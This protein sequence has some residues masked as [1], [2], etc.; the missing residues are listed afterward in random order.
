LCRSG[1]LKQYQGPADFKFPDKFDLSSFDLLL[2]E[3]IRR[4]QNTTVL[5]Y[6]RSAERCRANEPLVQKELGIHCPEVVGEVVQVCT[7]EE[8]KWIANPK[9]WGAWLLSAAAL[10]GALSVLRDN[11]TEWFGTPDVIGFVA[12]SVPPNI[13]SGDPLDIAFRVRNQARDGKAQVTIHSVTLKSADGRE[14]TDL[15]ADVVQITQL[16]AGQNADVHLTGVSPSVASPKR[17]VIEIDAEAGAG[18]LMGNQKVQY[19]PF[20]MICWPDRA[21]DFQVFQTGPA[22]ARV[23]VTLNAGVAVGTGLNGQLIV[24]SPVPLEPNGIISMSGT[25]SADPPVIDNSRTPSV[26]TIRFRTDAIQTFHRHSYSI[27]LAFK[28]PLTQHEW[29]SLPSWIKVVFA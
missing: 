7:P 5:L 21:W 16:Q 29:E 24:Q 28:R 18:R 20:T 23:V 26:G 9:K 19:R 12:D 27:A 22:V 25:G 6:W 17:Y 1:Y 14:H 10:F 4:G 8:P 13:H 2:T 3:S 11:F 15:Q